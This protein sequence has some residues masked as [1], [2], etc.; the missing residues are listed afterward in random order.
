MNRSLFLAF[1]TLGCPAANW[2][3][4]AAIARSHRFPGIE[5]R[6]LRGRTDLPA[7]LKEEFATPEKMA[8]A[9]AASGLRVASLDGSLR[10]ADASAAHR[11]EIAELAV[12]A[13][14]LGVPWLRVFDGGEND[15]G[16]RPEIRRAI[17]D[18]LAR[19]AD[20]RAEKG[21]RCDLVI[22]T[23]WALTD[24]DHCVRLAEELNGSLNL[25]WDVC[26]VWRQKRI[27]PVEDWKKLRPW[28]RHIHIKDLAADPASPEKLRYVV[29]GEG[30]VPIPAL[31]ELLERE[32]FAGAVS[33]EWE[34]LWNPDLP[35]L[36]AALAS[37]A[38][39][40]WW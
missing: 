34:L 39:H 27:S 14:A 40:G 4:A 23:H 12:W 31:L 7:L 9:V 2:E 19:W 3:E 35:P 10:L 16:S 24:P 13:D 38:R 8:A 22:E 20:L 26:H 11:A 33:L 1:S 29:P 32:R 28:V 15:S 30:I 6:S 21:F 18:E 25:L 36:E 17:R 37:G 5:L